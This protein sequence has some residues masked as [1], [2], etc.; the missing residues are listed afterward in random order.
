MAYDQSQDMSIEQASELLHLQMIEFQLRCAR[1]GISL[2]FGPTT[3][4]E[5]LEEVR[6]AADF[7]DAMMLN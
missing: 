1:L 2:Y 3:R 7:P 5:L 6:A 4:E